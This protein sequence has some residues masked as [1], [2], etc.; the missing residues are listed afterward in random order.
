MSEQRFATPRPVR[1]EIRIG[2]GDVEVQTIDGAESSVSLAGAQKLV[3]ATKVELLG[4]RLVVRLPRRGL[5]GLLGFLDQPLRVRV[6]IPHGSRVDTA[7]ASANASL[8]GTFGGVEAKSA[9]GD[10]HVAGE[11]HG[12][13]TVKNVG[14]SIRLGRVAGDLTVRSV[15]GAVDA[16]AVEGSASAK[17][18]SGDVRIGSVRRGTVSVQSVSGD[19]Q[20]G[21]AAGTNVDVD[22]S[23]ASGDLSSEVPL[24]EQPAADAA[25]TVVVRSNTVSGNFRLFRAA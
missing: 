18:V 7:T 8:L 12:D 4:D 10:V 11:I 3:E 19:V 9:S 24:S 21:V 22:A 13:A 2:A 16:E 17:S 5:T 25:S 20:L 14:G 23:S 6:R 1:L 15:S